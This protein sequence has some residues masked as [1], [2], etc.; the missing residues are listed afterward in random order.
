MSENNLAVVRNAD[1]P[2]IPE[3]LIG[4]GLEAMDRGDLIIPRARVIQ[5]TSKLDGRPGQFHF[6]LTGECKDSIHA[7]LL[8]MS[9]GRVY[10]SADLAADPLCASDDARTPREQREGYGPTCDA[11]P[12]SQWG[13]EG[14]PP[15]CSLVY[16][17]LAADL[18]DDN[19]PFLLALHGSSVKHAK[20]VLSAF[21]LKHLPLFSQPVQIDAIEVKN[22]KGRFYEV[23]MRPNDGGR[24]FDWR[25]FA[26][27]YR[28]Y[29][30]TTIRADADRED[31]A[32]EAKAEADDPDLLDDAAEA[33]PF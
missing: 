20:T 25:P 32:A 7:V 13:D 8:N 18:D 15:K 16:N 27:M 30:H 9:K 21:A 33:L 31:F 1:V 26:E 5:P 12:F 2:A 22:D 23:V 24:P 17:F 19:T 29:K 11:C 14:Q 28:A 4:A 10:W 3:E 6:N